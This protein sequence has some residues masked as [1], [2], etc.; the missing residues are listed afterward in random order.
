MQEESFMA[1]FTEYSIGMN[2]CQKS[3]SEMNPTK[4]DVNSNSLFISPE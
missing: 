2:D 3:F 1:E 4:A